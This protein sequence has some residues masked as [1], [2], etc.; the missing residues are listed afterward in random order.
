MDD[1]DFVI[2]TSS[3]DDDNDDP[4]SSDDEAKLRYKRMLRQR[5]KVQVFYP[6]VKRRK[7][8]WQLYR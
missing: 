6:S 8:L 3:H 5:K 7:C 1:A 2:P 4:A